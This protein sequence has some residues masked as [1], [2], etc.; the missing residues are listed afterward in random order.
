MCVIY[1]PS[2]WLSNLTISVSGYSLYS[3]LLLLAILAVFKTRFTY[4]PAMMVDSIEICIY[5][6]I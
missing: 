5:N 2:K 6:V 1:E 4:D 3:T